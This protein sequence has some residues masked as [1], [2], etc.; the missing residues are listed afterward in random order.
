MT[1]VEA[2]LEQK[3]DNALDE[4]NSKGCDRCR[5]EELLEQ[6]FV[7]NPEIL[8]IT[9]QVRYL[10]VLIPQFNGLDPPEI[11]VLSYVR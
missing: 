4:A 10:S 9:Q 11:I 2:C 8:Q 5:H 7:S 6:I 1:I 3:L